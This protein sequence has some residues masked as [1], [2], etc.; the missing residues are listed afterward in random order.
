MGTRESIFYSVHDERQQDVL[1]GKTIF[2]DGFRGFPSGP[3]NLVLRCVF[4][5]VGGSPYSGREIGGGSAI[6]PRLHGYTSQYLWHELATNVN[7][8]PKQ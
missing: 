8:T 4:L 6:P 2:R 1:F 7:N 3:G 5:Q